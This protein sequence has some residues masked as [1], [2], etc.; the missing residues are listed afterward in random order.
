MIIR[1][2]RLLGHSTKLIWLVFLL[3]CSKSEKENELP[4]PIIPSQEIG[5]KEINPSIF[6][7]SPIVPLFDVPKYMDIP[8]KEFSAAQVLFYAGFGG[9]PEDGTLELQNFNALVNWMDQNGLSSHVHM[10]VG[11]NFYMPDWLKNGTWTN[12]ELDGHLKNLIHGILDANGNADKIDVWNI[13]NE[14]FNQDGTYVDGSD[15]LWNQLGWED[16]TSGLTGDDKINDKHPIFI[17]KAFTYAREKTDKIL[18]YRDYL[19]EN[20]NP[21]SGWDEKQKAVVQLIKHMQNSNIPIDAVGIQGH[22]DIGNADWVLQNDGVKKA[23]EKF[24]SLGVEV[25]FTEI[26]FGAGEKLWTPELAQQQKEDYYNYIRQA[27]EGGATRIYTWGV[28]DGL[29]KGWRTN[30]HPLPWDEN[31]DKKPAYQGISEA[32]KD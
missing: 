2:F 16:D 11:P 6:I 24:K 18:E 9:W 31:L 32:L 28:Q 26:D 1:I 19:I 23:A 7:G 15:M 25:H 8:L 14:V 29:D 4:G 10:L 27:I 12:A 5:L 3:S 22:H 21:N 20:E 30:E 17:R 13:A